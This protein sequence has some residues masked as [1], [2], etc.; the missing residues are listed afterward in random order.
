MPP[1]RHYQF[2]QDGKVVDLSI[3]DILDMYPNEKYPNITRPAVS[4]ALR[5]IALKDLTPLELAKENQ[6]YLE[7]RL[8]SKR[9]AKNK[10]TSFVVDNG[11]KKMSIA[12]AIN[13]FKPKRKESAI[14]RELREIKK[15]YCPG[16]QPHKNTQVMLKKQKEPDSYEAYLKSIAEER[17]RLTVIFNGHLSI[18]VPGS[19]KGSKAGDYYEGMR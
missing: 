5:R 15:E 17:S 8:S 18:P 13:F 16:E 12:E 1:I 11:I 3:Y 2:F 4:S 14:R 7:V 9:I 10:R 6:A 19:F